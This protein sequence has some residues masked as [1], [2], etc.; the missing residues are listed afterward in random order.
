MSRYFTVIKLV[1]VLMLFFG[2]YGCDIGET[3]IRIDF[4]S[5]GGTEVDSIITDG[6]SRVSMPE[7]PEKE[8]YEFEGWYWDD[9]TF[10]D[11]F[12]A[13]SLKDRPLSENFTVYAKWA[14][15]G[16]GR[17]S[18]SVEVQFDSI[19]GSEVVPVYVQ[20]GNTIPAPSVSKEGHT[21]EGWYTSINEGETLDE[22]WSFSSNSVNYDLTL[23]ANW[24]I[25]EYTITFDA[26]GGR[27]VNDITQDYDTDLSLPN[28]NRTG[29]S[30]V[31]WYEDEGLNKQFELSEMPAE[32]L[33]LY[34]KWEINEYTISFESK[35]GTTVDS[36]ITDGESRVSIPEDPEK[37]GYE[38]DGWYEDEDLN[39]PFELSEMPAEDLTLHAKWEINEY[40]IS[41]DLDSG[42]NDSSNVEKYTV[43]EQITLH[44]ANKKGHTFLG[45]YESS[46]FEGQAVT[47][48]PLGTT[49]NLTL[50]A[51]WDINEYT[52]TYGIVAEDLDPLQD[53]A[54]NPGETL[55]QVS[56]GGSHSSALTSEG[57]LFTWGRNNFGQLGDGTTT[58]DANPN[59][60]E[61]TSTFD[62]AEGETLTQV[63]LNSYHSSALT[64]EGRLFTWG[65]NNKGHLG[66]GTTTNR[67]T[68]TEITS[69]FD[70]AEGE[71]LTQVSLGYWH[72]SVFTS[73]GR[74]FT[75]GLN[76]SG[77]LGDGTTTDRHTPTEIS[78]TFD[79]AEGETLTQVS[80]GNRHSSAFTSEGRLFTWGGNSRGQLG[81]GTTTARYTPTEVNYYTPELILISSNDYQE[82]IEAYVPTKEGYTIDGWY[83][84]IDLSTPYSFTTMPAED[85][86]LYAKWVAEE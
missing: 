45:W 18:G 65:R 69:G 80:L 60:T 16:E 27:T 34:A 4:E 64:S 52:I 44:D 68:P 3:E 29:H 5:N 74:L 83:R 51:K 35:G 81:D 6:E 25:N 71:T 86:T 67:H 47:E 23:Y 24:E 39:K 56:L 37:E 79:L 38:F 33:T 66:D 20:P 82:N 54:L 75:W 43:E 32:D 63:S 85:L 61:I 42:I 57:R 59:P 76:S 49:G 26:N 53:I 36:I 46:E 12:T 28:A 70:L 9:E 14:E 78:S 22:R 2:L 30:F 1:F 58:W 21:L 62:L 11:S 48:I 72:S 40:E 19:G 41:Y 13:N 7:D 73:E 8:G 10:R 55:T 50:Y 17:P 31:G 77:Q 15:D 84:D